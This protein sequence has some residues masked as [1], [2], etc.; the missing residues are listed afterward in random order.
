MG[1]LVLR[2]FWILT[3]GQACFLSASIIMMVCSVSVSNL[4]M[5]CLLLVSYSIFMM[6]RMCFFWISVSTFMMVCS[7]AITTIALLILQGS[8]YIPYSYGVK[9]YLLDGT[10][11][12]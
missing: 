3:V 7:L 11:S 10:C 2:L 5:I 8:R 4:A 6:N 12:C 9:I 1:K